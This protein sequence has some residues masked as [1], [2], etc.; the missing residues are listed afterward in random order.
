MMDLNG[1]G[2]LSHGEI[3]EGILKNC[4]DATEEMIHVIISD[5]DTNEDGKVSY[6]GKEGKLLSNGPSLI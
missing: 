2:V 4:V 5:A 3:K 6:T 1:D